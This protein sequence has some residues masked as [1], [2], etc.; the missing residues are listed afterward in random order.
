MGE[1]VTTRARALESEKGET[2]RDHYP[3]LA[4]AK[5]PFT[6]HESRGREDSD[7]TEHRR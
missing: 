2:R 4:S 3:L 1:E 5:A 6:V 7:G